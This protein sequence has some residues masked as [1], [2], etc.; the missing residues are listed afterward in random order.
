V[1]FLCFFAGY[2]FVLLRRMK[3]V[4]KKNEKNEVGAAKPASSFDFLKN[5]PAYF[6]LSFPSEEGKE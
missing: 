1:V 2:F 4:Q 5:T 6:F 3:K